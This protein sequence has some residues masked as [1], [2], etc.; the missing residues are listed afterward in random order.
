MPVT[1]DEVLRVLNRDELRYEEAAQLG[2]DALPHLMDLVRQGDPMIAS[3]ATYLASLI[4]GEQAQD[5][6][7]AAASMDDPRVRIAAAAALRNL[8]PRSGEL[9]SQ[10]LEDDDSGVR[11]VVLRSIR[12]RQPEAAR[13]M[14]DRV[15]TSDP[16]P[17]LRELAAEVARDL[18]G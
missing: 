13:S 10:L 3:K 8:D 14:V 15:A 11:K 9:F 4:G 17:Y 5:V 18:P 12:E 16:Q 6:V 2:P 7:E 1:K